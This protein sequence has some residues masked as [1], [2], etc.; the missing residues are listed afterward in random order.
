MGAEI[1]NFEMGRLNVGRDRIGE[2]VRIWI[3]CETK[4]GCRVFDNTLNKAISSLSL[5]GASYVADSVI[6]YLNLSGGLTKV[7]LEELM[8][9]LGDEWH[10]DQL[11]VI[12]RKS[13][14]ISERIFRAADIVYPRLAE[15]YISEVDEDVAS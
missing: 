14:K 5:L 15:V 10:E 2:V 3:E 1:L 9:A 4:K 7:V 6:E 12:S 13:V 11:M 8:D